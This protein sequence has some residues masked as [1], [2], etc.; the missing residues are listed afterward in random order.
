MAITT[1]TFL[2][3]LINSKLLKKL[4]KKKLKSEK[5]NQKKLYIINIEFCQ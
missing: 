3:K 4:K 2:H 5:P 1:S